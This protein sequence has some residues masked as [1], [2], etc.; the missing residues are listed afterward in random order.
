MRFFRKPREQQLLED[1]TNFKQAFS[2][3]AGKRTLRILQSKFWFL[4]PTFAP[5]DPV[6]TAFR[7]GQRSVVLAIMETLGQDLTQIEEQIE[8]QK[9]EE[10]N[11]V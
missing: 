1:V 10:E 2:T 3:D 6:T 11:H 9:R 4:M 8:Q 7:E 5:G